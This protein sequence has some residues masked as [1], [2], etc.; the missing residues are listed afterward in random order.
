MLL[1]SISSFLALFN[2]THT[3][4]HNLRFPRW[5]SLYLH[6]PTHRRNSPS[7]GLPQ[8][9]GG[10]QEIEEAPHLDDRLGGGEH[11]VRLGEVLGAPPS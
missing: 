3:H 1:L 9:L 5:F 2:R 6:S 8:G 11:R 4:L 10:E 7:L